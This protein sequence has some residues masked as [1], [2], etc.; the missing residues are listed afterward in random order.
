VAHYS[1]RE[2]E[3]L[4]GIKA[5]TIRIWE[6]RYGILSP[7]RTGTNIRYYDDADLKTILNISLLNNRGY[8]ISKIARLSSSQIAGEV[9]AL[10]S[11]ELDYPQQVNALILAMI[12]LDEEKFDRSFT[13]P[14]LQM[15]FENAM[16]R[17][18]YPFMERIGILW[19]TGNIN[20]AHEHFVSNLIRQKLIVAIDGQIGR[21]SPD[22]A[23]FVLFLPE[24]ELHE[25]ALLFMHFLLRTRQYPV[26]YLG[27]NLPMADL[28]TACAQ[29]K[30]DYLLTVCTSAPDLIEPYLRTLSQNF[31]QQQILVYGALV[32]Q[33]DLIFPAGIKKLT[34]INDFIKVLEDKV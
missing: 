33:P 5:H 29:Y 14:V 19:Q 28:L 24:G 21:W 25:I 27:Q 9:V 22:A 32:Q 16:L 17:I 13:Q 2:L 23:R 30:P 26:L 8:K 12:E 20:P 3:H 4:S 31:P 15:G 34:V 10:C 1:I 11:A 7:K 6:Q 18:V